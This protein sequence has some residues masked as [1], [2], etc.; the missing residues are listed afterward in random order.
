[1]GWKTP[2]KENDASNIEDEN[3]WSS[4]LVWSDAFTAGNSLG[5]AYGTAE[6]HRD[7][8]SYDDPMAW[9]FYYS[10][11]V[12]DNITVT[13]ALFVVQRDGE[14]N[15]DYTGGVIKTTFSF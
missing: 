7:D 1:M 9:E 13:P 6:G 5:I 14:Q 3:T 4:G 15:E 8:S 2:E 12:S 10:I 11:S